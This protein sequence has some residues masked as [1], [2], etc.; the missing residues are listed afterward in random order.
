MLSLV[1]TWMGDRL[2]TLG[3]VGIYFSIFSLLLFCCCCSLASSSSSLYKRCGGALKKYHLSD[4]NYLFSK[5]LTSHVNYILS[6]LIFPFFQMHLQCFFTLSKL[7]LHFFK[8]TSN[9]FF[10][11][12]KKKYQIGQILKPKLE[13]K[14]MPT[15]PS[16]PRRSPIQVLTRLNTA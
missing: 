11:K 9:V 14:I 16:V 8:C 2:G 1:S 10:Q 7:I 13:K 6:K 5:L 3:A 4:F 12:L 15:A